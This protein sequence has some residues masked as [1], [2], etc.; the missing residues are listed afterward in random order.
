MIFEGEEFSAFSVAC[1]ILKHEKHI[2]APP[3]HVMQKVLTFFRFFLPALRQ[4]TR[5]T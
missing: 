5:C 4:L 3:G 2:Q 1:I